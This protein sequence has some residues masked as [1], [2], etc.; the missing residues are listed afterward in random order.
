MLKKAQVM[1]DITRQ[2]RGGY[3]KKSDPGKIGPK[4]SSDR[5]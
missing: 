3:M 1:Y 5:L 4:K 2:H